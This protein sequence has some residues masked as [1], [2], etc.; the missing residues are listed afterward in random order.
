MICTF[1]CSP[2]SGAVAKHDW[3]DEDGAKIYT[4]IIIYIIIYNYICIYTN[5]GTPNDPKSDTLHWN[6]WFWG[7]QFKKPHMKPWKYQKITS[8]SQYSKS[9]WLHSKGNSSEHQLAKKQHPLRKNCKHGF[10][11]FVFSEAWSWLCLWQCNLQRYGT[12]ISNAFLHQ[13]DH[14]AP[15]NDMGLKPCSTS[16]PNSHL[17]IIDFFDDLLW[18]TWI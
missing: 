4:Y 16:L 13:S 8:P 2:L 10:H 17:V 18:S 3:F 5:G 14:S 7:S 15:F 11:G 12:L 6:P 9:Q 1:I